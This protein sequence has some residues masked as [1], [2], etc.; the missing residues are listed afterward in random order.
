MKSRRKSRAAR[1]RKRDS[2]GHFVK[3]A[4]RRRKRR[5]AKRRS[6]AAAKSP[7]RRRRRRAA[8]PAAA[9]RRHRR[10]ARAAAPASAPRQRLRRA[11][12][13]AAAPRRRRR[14]ARAQDWPGHPR[15]H[16]K[17]AL[18]G[19]R[20]RKRR[21]AAA[22]KRHRARRSRA[23]EWYGQP[24]RHRKAA[25][26]GWARRRRAQRAAS[27][28]SS[29]RR[30]RRASPR[31]R[32]ARRASYKYGKKRYTKRTGRSHRLPAHRYEPKDSDY[33][34]GGVFED[35]Y[36]LSNPL[37]GG[38]LVLVGI[39][40]IIGYGLAD[41]V[42]RYMET[43][44]VA[45]GQPANS[46]PAGAVV[47]NDVATGA[48][49]SWQSLAAQFGVAA[50]P[51]IAAAFVDSPWGRAALQGMMLGAGFSLFG[52]LFKSLMA[53]M[54][55]TTALG[56]QLYLAE[57]EAQAAVTAGGTAAPA[58]LPT[59]ST[60]APTAAPATSLQG[61]PRGV[62]R[63]PMLRS[64]DPGPRAVGRGVGQS[65]ANAGNAPVVAQGLPMTFSPGITANMPPY[66]PGGPGNAPPGLPNT[67]VPP[68]ISNPN[69][70]AIPVGYPAN[71][72]QMPPGILTNTGDVVP[73][74]TPGASTGPAGPSTGPMCAPCTS[75]NG[76]IA[77]T[78][79]SAMAAIRDESCL[80]ALP[81]NFT[82]YHSFPDE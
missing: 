39:T 10:P 71:P 74:G 81:K 5:V 41:F 43:T 66:S 7:T 14:R 63:R 47:G 48:F 25:K 69:T 54:I 59:T 29:P 75:T 16:R 17:A 76:G 31:R 80:G 40:G 79:Q 82:M 57:T 65:A 23:R 72:L 67:S 52:G 11:A 53:S 4:P 58:A 26:K 56:Q 45:S 21:L 33:G 8:A 44:A 30:S 38:E 55:G 20:R 62:G 32:S 51:G 19:I 18:K 42:G 68:P 2:K 12:A 37:S 36:V 49:P 64:T 24:R 34:Q 50:V 28:R 15:L 27:R 46:I 9:P 70:P 78:H 61:L 3:A 22:P 13:P 60:A 6:R 73:S 77:A 1:G 35:N